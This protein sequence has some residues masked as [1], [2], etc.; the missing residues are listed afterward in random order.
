[1]VKTYAKTAI[2]VIN[3]DCWENRSHLM[4]CSAF[5]C[6]SWASCIALKRW[7]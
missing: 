2:S 3:S 7:I 4:T 6:V 5:L 1:M